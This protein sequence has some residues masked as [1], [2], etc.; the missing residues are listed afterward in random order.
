MLQNDNDDFTKENIN[1]YN[2]NWSQIPDHSY[3][4]Y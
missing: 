2:L 1:K 4:E 3:R